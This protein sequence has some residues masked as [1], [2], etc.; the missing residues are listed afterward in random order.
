MAVGNQQRTMKVVGILSWVVHALVGAFF[1]FFLVWAI[2]GDSRPGDS[3][4]SIAEVLFANVLPWLVLTGLAIWQWLEG[5]LWAP[6]VAA[7]ID[8]GLLY[9]LFLGIP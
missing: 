7:A 1:G 5:R 6:L 3:T 2:F 8:M 9:L 4:S